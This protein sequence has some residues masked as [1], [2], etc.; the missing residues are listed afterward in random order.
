MGLSPLGLMAAGLALDRI[1]G[2]G[3]LVAMGALLLVAS[4][5]FALSGALRGARVQ[6]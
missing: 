1:S 2:V 6:A 5:L 3:T 4:G